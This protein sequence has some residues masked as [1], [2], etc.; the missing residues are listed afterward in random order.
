MPNDT[1]RSIPMT[2]CNESSPWRVLGFSMA[3]ASHARSG[4]PCQDAH[5]YRRVAGDWVAIAVADGAGSARLAENGARAA[6]DVAVD[7]LSEHIR[8]GIGGCRRA[9]DPDSSD[10][11][12]AWHAAMLGIL[13]QCR[14]VVAREAVARDAR[15]GDL[16][17]T[18]LVVALGPGTVAAIQVGDGGTVVERRDGTVEALTRPEPGEYINEVTFITSQ[19]AMASARFAFLDEAIRSA[20]VLTDG[21]QLLT[22]RYPDWTPHAPFF[23]PVFQFLR[24][25]GDERAAHREIEAMLQSPAVRDRTDDDVTLLVA[26]RVLDPQDAAVGSVSS[27]PRAEAQ[28]ERVVDGIHPGDD[29]GTTP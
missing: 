10:R 25:Q 2:E 14:D 26:S 8:A 29:G 1:K 22:L 7:L 21:L 24:D 17:C 9:A 11:A 20:A 27:P 3:G 23:R 18:L 19:N 13:E 6:V 12:E 28:A 5:A 4:V 16:A 15:P